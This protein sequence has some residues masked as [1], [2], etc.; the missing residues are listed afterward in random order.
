MAKK[1]LFLVNYSVFNYPQG[2]LKL[3]I[4]NNLS[5]EM[6]ETDF[7]KYN[8]AGIEEYLINFSTNVC[9]SSPFVT[10]YISKFILKKFLSDKSFF[11][12]Y[13]LNDKGHYENKIRNGG[14]LINVIFI[15]GKNQ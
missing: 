8:I 13:K 7:V 14:Q 15:T 10:F 12:K 1:K 6:E 5:K 11:L 9:Y 4:T 2:T 3:K